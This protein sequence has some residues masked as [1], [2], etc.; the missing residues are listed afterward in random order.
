[1]LENF[2]FVHKFFFESFWFMNSYSVGYL[3]SIYLL[4]KHCEMLHI[5]HNNPA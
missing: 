4:E 3:I 5:W 2:V 1:M